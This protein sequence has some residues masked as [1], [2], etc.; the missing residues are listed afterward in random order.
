MRKLLTVIIFLTSGICYS[1]TWYELN[2]TTAN[3]YDIKASSDGTG[4]VAS[5]VPGRLWYYNGS[6]NEIR[7]N[8]Y[9]SS[10]NYYK[11]SI[12]GD[13]E[14]MLIPVAG[15]RLWYYDG[16][17]W[18]EQNPPGGNA[19]NRNWYVCAISS[20]GNTMIAGVSNGRLY[21]YSGGTWSEIQPGGYNGDR[22]WT[23]A[24]I[25]S[26]GTRYAVCYE[27][28]SIGRIWYWNGTSWV[29]K[30]PA[31]NVE[32]RWRGLDIS[33]DGT[34]LIA[35]AYSGRIY[36]STNS[37][38]NW[39]E[40]YPPGG[41]AA[42]QYWQSAAISAD[43]TYMITGMTTGPVYTYNGSLWTSN[44]LG[45]SSRTVYNIDAINNAYYYAPAYG[46]KVYATTTTTNIKSVNG[47]SQATLNKINSVL[48]STIKKVNS[49]SNN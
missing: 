11:V 5:I 16:S 4:V 14:K 18:V 45:G 7:P 36:T 31:G 13:G 20:D 41:T 46:N 26:D 6:W 30:Q 1:Q 38:A 24:T 3:W 17:F 43:G 35:A 47:V 25:N 10:Y 49:V 29:E 2:T 33:G 28:A 40:I 12:S 22:P 9:D 39:T 15:R 19:I 8:T 23:T 32:R 37:G 21:L 34:K 42:N 27:N 48:K 44:S